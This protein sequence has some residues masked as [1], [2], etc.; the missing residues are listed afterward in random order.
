MV[1]PESSHIP[2]VLI[3]DAD[4]ER[5]GR[6]SS[7]LMAGGMI[8]SVYPD[9]STLLTTV[10]SETPE[11][12]IV[13]LDV[14]PHGGLAL[15]RTLKNDSVFAHLPVLLVVPDADLARI[16]TTGEYLF[17]DYIGP[18]PSSEDLLTR[19]LLCVHRTL[20][21][22]DA[23]PLTRLPGN[24]SITTEME[25]RIARKE[26]FATVYVD[27]GDFKAFNDRYGFSRG[28]EALR[29]TAR[30]VVSCVSANSPQDYYIGHVGGDDFIFIV[31][32]DRAE[33]I[34]AQFI[35][36]FD[37]IIGAMYDEEDRRRGYIQGVDRRGETET[38]PQMT[39]S[40]AVVV[41]RHGQFEH[42]GEISEIAAELKK[43]IKQVPKSGFLVDRRE[44][45]RK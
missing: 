32:C 13:G 4:A 33:A 28:D 14:P 41:N 39:V 42:P 11:L 43:K 25:I 20:R 26:E 17:D 37:E 22:L 36:S 9:G 45:V 2:R 24:N 5:A 44:K 30:L 15:A 7:R 3:L 8:T 18:D 34:C 12:V 16:R 29:L 19:A 35:R 21:Q 40:L 27:L 23:S 38:F 10:H 6:L 1:L 31:P